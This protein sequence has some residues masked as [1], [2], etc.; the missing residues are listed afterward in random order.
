VPAAAP[1]QERHGLQPGTPAPPSANPSAAIKDMTL[2]EIIRTTVGGTAVRIKISN[3]YGT[4]PVHI[5]Q[6]FIAER[7]SGSKTQEPVQLHF[8]GAQSIDV[9]AGGEVLSDPASFTV[10]PQA[11][12]AVSL[13][14][15]DAK[16]STGHLLQR[17]NIY[18]AHG[19]VASHTD[20]VTADGPENT[21]A[22][23]LFLSEVEVT[24]PDAT[25]TIVAFGDSITDGLGTTS[26][27]AAS[28]PDRLFERLKPVDGHISIINAGITGN[29]LTRSAQW[30]PFGEGGLVRFDRDVLSQPGVA[31]VIVLIGINDIGQTAAGNPDY[32]APTEIEAGLTQLAARAHEHGVKFFAGTLLP[33]KGAKDGYYSD[34]KEAL[35][36]TVNKW[37]RQN[38]SFNGV[39]DLDKV[40]QDPSDPAELRPQYDSGDHLHPNNDGAQAIADAIALTWFTDNTGAKP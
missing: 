17:S 38:K 11:D 20:I 19:N 6:A 24:R 23:W 15:P 36:Q 37:I 3:A 35:R 8:Q 12:L 21:W 25:Q 18:F 32:A 9:P 31:W 22:S 5:D 14:V 13:Y 2:R 26:D 1:Q 4:A 28:W 40:M 29:R 10:R 30:A 34:E 39:V 16:A 27:A 33:F 7:I